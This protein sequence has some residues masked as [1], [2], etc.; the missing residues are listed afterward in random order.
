MLVLTGKDRHDEVWRSSSDAVS[1]PQA[2]R[3]LHICKEVHPVSLAHIVRRKWVR[4][5]SRARGGE[6]RREA[7]GEE[8][9]PER[10]DNQRLKGREVCAG[11]WDA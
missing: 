2:R 1:P 9:V 10:R 8:A 7:L 5:Y 3:T 6:H 11:R 4:V